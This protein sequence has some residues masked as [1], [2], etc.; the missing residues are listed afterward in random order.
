[1]VTSHPA[2]ESHKSEEK[3]KSFSML[4]LIKIPKLSI[5]KGTAQKLLL[6]QPETQ[7]KPTAKIL[8]PI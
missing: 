2:K 8:Q 7:V 6:S 4:K 1:M 5:T 3:K